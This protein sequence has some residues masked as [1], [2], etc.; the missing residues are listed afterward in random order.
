MK[1]LVVG[2]LALVSLA[3]CGGA[4][5]P[6]AAVAKEAPSRFHQGDFV[7][8]RY[9]G[10]FTK[11]PVEMRE[12]VV[13]QHGNQLTIDV[14]VTRG[15]EQRHWQ[16]IVTDTPANEKNNVVDAL[17]EYAGSE[18]KK[19]D[20]VGNADLLR[21]NAWTML[22]PDGKA[23]DVHTERAMFEIAH[24]SFTCERTSGKNRW[25][26]RVVK[27]E[28]FDCPEFLWKH[29]RARFSDDATGEEVLRAEVSDVGN[30]P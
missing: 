9:T 7:A 15:G 8:Y 30:A 13:E 24:D 14:V 3:A 2:S 4:A 16:Q 21:L 29:G 26:G 12:R 20:N 1:S 22:T 6:K 19:L 5:P 18:R 28:S 11:E 23:E 27:F 25:H 17:Y 10:L